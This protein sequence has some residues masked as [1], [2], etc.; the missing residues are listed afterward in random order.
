KNTVAEI[1]SHNKNISPEKA[2]HLAE[3]LSTGTWTHDYPIT[4][5]EARSLGL[6]VST[7]MPEEIYRLMTMYPQAG[8]KRP[9]VSYI[10]IPYQQ[11]ERRNGK[12]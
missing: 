4:V 10:P 8:H 7:D 12:S 9:S 6:P 5:D 1:L 2:E 11:P 3:L